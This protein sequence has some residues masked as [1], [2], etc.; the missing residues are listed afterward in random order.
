M[1][2]VDIYFK[3]PRPVLVKC[4]GAVG[5]LPLIDVY[6]HFSGLESLFGDLPVC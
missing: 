5:H 2:F 4:A 1:T 6:D 3:I